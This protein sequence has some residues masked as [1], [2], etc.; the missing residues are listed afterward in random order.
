MRDYLPKSGPPPAWN[1]M[2]QERRCAT[3]GTPM[4]GRECPGCRSVATQSSGEPVRAKAKVSQPGDRLEQEADRVADAIVDGRPAAA[5]GPSA[6]PRGQVQRAPADNLPDDALAD[7]EEEEEEDEETLEEAI[8]DFDEVEP[9]ESL[10]IS[11]AP[12]QR[13]AQR[14]TDATPAI[15]RGAGAPMGAE[16][17]RFMESRFGHSFA[18]V[19]V[20]ADDAAASSADR[21]GAKAYTHGSHIYFADGQYRPS[22][23][24]GQ[25][26]L[27]HELT[28]VLQQRAGAQGVFAQKGGKPAK[29]VKPKPARPKRIKVFLDQQKAVAMEGDKV[30]RT[31]SISSGKPGHPTDPGT[32]SV[33]EKDA[34]HSSSKYG[35]CGTR[36][37]SKGRAACAKGET[38]VGAPMKHFL[39][40]NGA[41]GFHK[42][43]LPGHPDSHGCVRLGAGNA[44]WLFN[45]AKVGTPVEV[46]KKTPAAKKKPTKKS[47]APKRKSRKR[48]P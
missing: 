3:C 25:R 23:T 12:V 43:V 35:K 7:L 5:P 45:W 48:A 2:R 8:D 41:E 29:P 44:K 10:K 47:A 42:G 26:L 13:K 1:A 39:R 34:D 15:P 24:D 32:F 21:I 22:T 16:A 36:S 4:E 6:A 17:S 20:H 46:L 9:A 11:E 19:R 28:H 30:V 40:F 18:D 27:A 33:T 38:Y 14:A 31:M 37:V